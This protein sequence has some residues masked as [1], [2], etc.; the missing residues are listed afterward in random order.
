MV[1]FLPA[2]SFSEVLKSV[3]R[4]DF[5]GKTVVGALIGGYIA[6]EI[7]KKLLGI[8]KRTGDSFAVAIPLAQGIGRFG[9]YLHGCC[10]GLPS[11]LPWSVNLW[12]TTRHPVQLYEAALDFSL[13]AIL[14]LS[15][16]TSYPNGHLFRR[17]ILGYACIRLVTDFFR[18]D[19]AIR[20]LSLTFVQWI[21]MGTAL[22]F[23]F[24]V[25]QGWKSDPTKESS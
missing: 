8:R 4:L 23:G 1:F 25:Y 3:T 15:R 19:P 5:S 20:F 17:Y 21:C 24:I 14:Y 22:I 6:V 16:R 11:D 9:C 7:A 10:F 2:S 18:G 12:N 13:A